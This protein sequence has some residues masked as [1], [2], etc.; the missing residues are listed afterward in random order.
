MSRPRILPDVIGASRN[1]RPHAVR[2][3]KRGSS[4]GMATSSGSRF[5]LVA[6]ESWR[7]IAF[8][9]APGATRTRSSSRRQRARRLRGAHGGGEPSCVRKPKQ[10]AD[11]PVGPKRARA[12]A[13]RV[14][15]IPPATVALSISAIRTQRD[16]GGLRAGERSRIR[17]SG[18]G[19]G[20]RAQG[21]ATSH[22]RAASIRERLR[23][24]LATSRSRDVSRSTR[25]P[26]SRATAIST[27]PPGGRRGSSFGATRVIAGTSVRAA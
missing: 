16:G 11:Q 27:S 8:G 24:S 10:A 3:R 4:S 19:S 18:A 17:E 9:R 13:V 22:G 5:A 7:R 20:L 2:R 23:I 21:A 26:F 15:Q 1:R 6:W 14:S 25:S 12:L